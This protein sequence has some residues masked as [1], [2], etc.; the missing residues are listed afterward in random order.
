MALMAFFRPFA[1]SGLG[2]AAE[3]LF[4]VNDY[5]APDFRDTALVPRVIAHW[6]LL[7]ERQR[8]LL[9]LLF[10]LVELAAPLLVPCLHRFSRLPVER[11]ESAVR[12]WR[13]SRVGVVRL[14]GDALKATLTLH[15]M[16]HPA[17]LRYVGADRV[18]DAAAA[19]SAPEAT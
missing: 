14:V 12:A 1:E 9:V 4:P 16:S 10:A 15:Y 8:R 13:L 11:R 18:G 6:E 3:A 5:G 17:A 2:A 19:A 7:P